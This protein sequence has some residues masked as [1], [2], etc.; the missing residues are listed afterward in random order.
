MRVH[1]NQVNPYAQL[2][3]LYAAQKAAAKREAAKTRRKLME[4]ASLLAGESDSEA[5]GVVKLE[6]RQ[7]SQEQN[8]RQNPSKQG[9]R[10]KANEAAASGDT[11]GSISEWA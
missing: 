1:A 10:K 6:A 11:D 4:S 3:A 2:D 5:A 9:T 8:Q 7:E